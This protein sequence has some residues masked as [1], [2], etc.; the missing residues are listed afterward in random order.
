MIIVEVTHDSYFGKGMGDTG[1]QS[2]ELYTS[3]DDS[4]KLVVG[5]NSLMLGAKG[6]DFEFFCNHQYRGSDIITP[7]FLF[8]GIPFELLRVVDS[9]KKL[10][11]TYLYPCRVG[12]YFCKCEDCGENFVIDCYKSSFYLAN[13][14]TVPTVRCK[15]CIDLRKA[16]KTRRK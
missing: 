8:K 9:N 16:N 13:D 6:E 12:T 11:S 7:Q 4:G 2:T 5:Y 10:L 3:V 15:K 1:V 14:L